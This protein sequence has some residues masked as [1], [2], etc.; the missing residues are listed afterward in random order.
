LGI[1]E[2]TIDDDPE[3]LTSVELWILGEIEMSELRSRY[4]SL[5]RQRARWNRS[6]RHPYNAHVDATDPQAGLLIETHGQDVRDDD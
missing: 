5:V 6:Q 2:L 1:A 4:N 3:F